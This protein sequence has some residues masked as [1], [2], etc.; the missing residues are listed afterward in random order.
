MRGIFH[1]HGIPLLM[2]IDK[3]HVVSMPA[4]KTENNPPVAGNGETPKSFQIPRQ[5]MHP[6]SLQIEQLFQACCG[7]QRE[8]YT[9]HTW[10]HIGT[11]PAPVSTLMETLQPFMFERLDHNC[12]PS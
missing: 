3:L 4:F 1:R 6:I 11:N 7:I 8:Q 2:I 9:P 5:R 10:E 12:K